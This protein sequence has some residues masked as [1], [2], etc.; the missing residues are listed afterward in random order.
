MKF[1]GDF[2]IH[3]IAS[4]DAFG[5]IGEIVQ[6]AR[7]RGFRAIAITEHGPKMEASAHWYYFN[8]LIDNVRED[9]GIIIYPG[10]EANIIN[11]EGEL[12]LP[13]QILERLE[14]INIAFHTFSWFESDMDI[15]TK[16]L[17]SSL[18]KYNVKSIAHLNYP[19]YL[20]DIN[21]IIPILLEKN[22]AIEINSKALKKV[23]NSWD[24]FK[25]IVI[26]CKRKGV[27]FLVNSDA[28]YPKQVG[29][30]S[31]ALEFIHYCKLEEEDIL[32]TD[33]N[34]MTKYFNLRR[35]D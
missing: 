14:F 3:T 1:I 32:N 11:E 8:S 13:D 6:V 19:Y 31:D 17:K 4:G 9:S 33:F 12:D 28:H 26:Q 23:K 34:N 16:A 2:H 7:E 25:D 18:L 15:N 5:T 20:I 27:K 35:C 22:I 10:V 24:I 29:E 21:E 30:F